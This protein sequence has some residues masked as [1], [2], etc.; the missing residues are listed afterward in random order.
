MMMT[1]SKI[2]LVNS[3]VKFPQHKWERHYMV[4]FTKNKG[5]PKELEHWQPTVDSMLENIESKGIIYFMADQGMVSSKSPQRRGG[6][7][8]DGVWTSVGHT[9]W[10]TRHRFMG[11]N[12]H[13][14]SSEEDQL[15]IL[16]SDVT[17]SAGYVGDW[18]GIA[19]KG[20]DCSHLKTNDF[21]SIPLEAGKVWAGSALNTLHEALTTN[22]PMQRTVVRLNVCLN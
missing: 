9:G 13:L 18:N 5:L 17:A 20:G 11:H 15:L 7:H 8:I 6:L 12:T 16:A 21:D 4:P 19:N 2:S 14:H 10:K 1:L 3:H 22:F